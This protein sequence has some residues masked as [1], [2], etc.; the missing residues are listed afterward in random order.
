DQAMGATKGHAQ[1]IDLSPENQQK[2]VEFERG[3]HTAQIFDN[4]AGPLFANGAQGGPGPL[5]TQSFG[6]GVN[7]KSVPGNT[8]TEEVFTLFT[9]WADS[10]GNG[11]LPAARAS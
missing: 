6:I 5:A 2:I 9:S 7:D 10:K 3:L 1:G 8:T 4:E 11:P